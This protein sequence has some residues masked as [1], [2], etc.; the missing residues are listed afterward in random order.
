MRL[1]WREIHRIQTNAL[2]EVLQKHQEVF[3]EG[4]GTLKGYTAKLH[5]NPGATPCFCKAQSVP[6]SMQALVDK[7]L[8]HLLE[9][10]VT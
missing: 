10:G 3:K 8:D 1:D 4:S 5:N 9:E 2:D 7:E 6:Y